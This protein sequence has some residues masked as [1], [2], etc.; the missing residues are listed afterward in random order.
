VLFSDPARRWRT[1]FQEEEPVASFPVVDMAAPSPPIQGSGPITIGHISFAGYEDCPTLQNEHV[2]VVL[3]PQCGGRVLEYSR[4]GENALMLDP[5]HDGWVAVPDRAPLGALF[6]SG[7][8]FDIGPE[9]I[10]PRHPALWYGPWRAQ[11]IAPQAVRLTSQCSDTLGVQLTRYFSLDPDS[12]RLTCTQ[13]IENISDH[14]VRWC[15][16]GRTFARG[17]GI[18]IVPLTPALSRFPSQYVM[19]G[20][21]SVIDYAPQDPAIRVRDG[22]LEVW[23][24]PARPKLGLDSYA[25]WFG[26]LMP[27]DLLLLKRFQADPGRVY[28]EIAALTI[29]LWYYQDVV[30]E[31]EPIG[32]LEALAPGAS[33][34]FMEEW[35]LLP[36]PFPMQRDALDL[37]AIQEAARQAMARRE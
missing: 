36:H 27:N 25:G 12:S 23:D 31:L 24:T 5:R 32:P 30:C 9:H 15:H 18:C 35:W 26:Y 11:A 1:A 17:H 34:S 13:A 33:A 28:N 6:P 4:R 21:G 22:F 20:P 29:S 37:V 7:G 3:S 8:R 16:W 14:E 2:R 10:I 19:Y